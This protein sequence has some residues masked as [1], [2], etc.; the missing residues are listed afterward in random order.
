MEDY[1]NCVK[2]YDAVIPLGVRYLIQAPSN[3]LDSWYPF[4]FGTRHSSVTSYD[5]NASKTWYAHTSRV[6]VQLIVAHIDSCARWHFYRLFDVFFSLQLSPVRVCT[7]EGSPRPY[8]YGG[9]YCRGFVRDREVAALRTDVTLRAAL[10]SFT[11]FA[12]LIQS[13]ASPIKDQSAP[14][15]G[16]NG[17]S[18]PFRRKYRLFH[19]LFP[20]CL[21]LLQ[22]Y[23]NPI[24]ILALSSLLR[25]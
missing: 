13:T 22:F 20:R 7:A 15:I 24:L 16:R 25:W 17:N 21:L 10:L 18:L 2:I 8:L 6:L 3:C 19:H 14:N 5:E 11:V 23:D 12:T 9:K 1:R 4:R